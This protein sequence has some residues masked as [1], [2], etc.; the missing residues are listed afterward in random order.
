MELSELTENRLKVALTGRL[1]AVGV[2]RIETRFL[3]ALAGGTRHVAVDLSQ[4][5]F[6]ASL[7]I[8]LLLS[9]ARSLSRKG[10][11]LVL[12]APQPPVREVFGH[13]AL[14][15]LIPIYD[16]EAQALDALKS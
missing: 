10:A 1:D 5:D 4:V 13:V 12:F 6:V 11:R 9:T 8:R 3:G 14:A 7:G 16:T 2:D 15:D